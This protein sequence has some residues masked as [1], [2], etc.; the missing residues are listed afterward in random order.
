[1]FFSDEEVAWQSR[2]EVKCMLC[3][4]GAFAAIIALFVHS[5]TMTGS[6]TQPQMPKMTPP[7]FPPTVVVDRQTPAP[8]PVSA[9]DGAAYTRA[10]TSPPAVQVT[11]TQN[12]LLP[13]ENRHDHNVCADDE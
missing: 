10:V 4:V 6:Q 1:M 13:V 3:G 5:L 8:V 2:L 7:A 11:T 9:V 12:P